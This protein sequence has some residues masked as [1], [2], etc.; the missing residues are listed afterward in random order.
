MKRALPTVLLL[1]WS[2]SAPARERPA[3]EPVYRSDDLALIVKTQEL[4]RPRIEA[5]LR[6]L[7]LKPGMTVLD[8]GAGTGQQ[9]YLLAGKVGP[10]GRV[11]ASDVEKRYVDYVNAQ[12]RGRGLKNLSA[13]QVDAA[14]VDPAYG[15]RAYDLILMYDMVNYLRERPD[16]YRGLRALLAPGGRVA[17]V[18]AESVPDHSFRPEDVRDWEGLRARLESEP[19]DSPVGRLLRKG[20]AGR[21]ERDL[22]F[23]LDRALDLKLYR[24]FSE[25]LSFKKDVSFAGP[26]RPY[27][28]WLL[29]RLALDDVSGRELGRVELQVF[30]LMQKLNKLLLISRYRPFL[31]FDGVH[32]YWSAGPETR[33]HLAHERRVEEMAEAG[34]ELE[35]RVP[36]P[37]FQA[38]WLF[39][40]RG[41]PSGR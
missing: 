1:L 3:Y 24:H 16:F 40:A 29:H 8:V 34:Y 11:Y 6:E 35:R 17:L 32:P 2:A 25:G 36:L 38:L 22:L 13:F 28:E 23:A 12:A 9:A 27:A 5:V 41:T 15:G 39:R 4:K 19:K 14:G 20:L 18:E 31:A 37:P 30:R 33:W 7:G 26:E 21:E 10:E